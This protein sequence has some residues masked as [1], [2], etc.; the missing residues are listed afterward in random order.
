MDRAIF[1]RVFHQGLRHKGVALSAGGE[2]MVRQMILHLLVLVFQLN[3][4]SGFEDVSL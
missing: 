4:E 3:T 2:R 1:L